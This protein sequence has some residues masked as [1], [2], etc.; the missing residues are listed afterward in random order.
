M[1][2]NNTK[3]IILQ[4]FADNTVGNISAETMRIF[5][6]DVFNDSEVKFNKFQTLQEFEAQDNPTIYEGSLVVIFNSSPAEQG[7]YYSTINQPKDRKFL[8]QLSSN[9]TS[10]TGITTTYEYVANANQNIF[11]CNYTDDLVTVY[12]D[13]FKVRESQ[14]MT[15]AKTSITLIEPLTGGEDVEIIGTVK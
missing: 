10:D 9:L 5:I 6:N 12:I 14:I 8:N 1:T 4:M 7:I 13:G 2:N 15:D 11:A 3:Q